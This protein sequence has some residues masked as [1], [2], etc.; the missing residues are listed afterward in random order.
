MISLIQYDEF[1][2]NMGFDSMRKHFAE[3]PYEGIEKI[4]DYLEA[5]KKT[6]AK[7]ARAID[8]FSGDP[9]N[10]EYVGMTDGEYSWNSVL[11]YYVEKYNL[12]LPEQF[13]KKVLNL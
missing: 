9:I 10:T 11:P 2:P 12:R 13:E 8:V 3:V 7:A 4:V 5:G 1:G 6:Y